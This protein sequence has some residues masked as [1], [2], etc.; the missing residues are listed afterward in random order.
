MELTYRQVGDYLIPNLELDK[1]PEGEIGAY[2]WMRKRYLKE[3]KK[4][5]YSKLL[6]NGTLQKHLLEINEQAL[7]MMESLTK[8]MAKNEGVTEQLK[9]TNQMAW[10]QRMN[11]IRNRAE[12][13]VRA[14][15]IYS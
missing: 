10:V 7:D 12:E 15:L 1:Q 13:I 6:L 11:N 3:H 4:G 5:I 9:L 8:Q 14:E 2:G